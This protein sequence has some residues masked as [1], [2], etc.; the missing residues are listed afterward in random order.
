MRM[1]ICV[2]LSVKVSLRTNQSSNITTM[3]VV[4]I[5][6]MYVVPVAHTYESHEV[7]TDKSHV[8]L[9]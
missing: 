5:A 8:A 2:C 3:Y 9:T 6:H 4:P 1:Y 7:C